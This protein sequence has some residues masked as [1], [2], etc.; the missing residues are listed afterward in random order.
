MAIRVLLNLLGGVALLL[1]G[2]HMVQSG[3][4]RAFGARLKRWLARVLRH[5][6]KA[7]LAGLVVTA[8]LQS[9]TATA[10]MI[11][12]FSAVNLVELTPALAVMLGANVGTTLV[13]Q[14]LSFDTSLLSPVLLFVGLI[15]FR[16]GAQTVTRDLGRV[17]IGLGLMLLA[18]HLM[19]ESLAPVEHAVLVH[20]LLAALGDEPLLM[21]LIGAALTWAAHSSVA[22]VLFAS[23]LA[24]TGALD[25]VPALVLVL[26]ANLGSAINPLLESHGG[27]PAHLRLPFANLLIRFIGCLVFLP[28]LD[29]AAR[30][31][32]GFEAN[33]LRQVADFHTL[34]NLLLAVAFFPALD[35]LA[36]LLERLL[37]DTRG[38]QDP[39]V[40]V[41]LDERALDVPAVALACAARETLRLGEL[42][43]TMLRQGMQAVFANDRKLASEVSRM[44]N[45][46]DR[47]HEAIKL[48]LVRLIRASDDEAVHRR[49]MELM[50]LALNLEHIGDIIDKNLMELATKKIKRHLE[51]SDEGRH[52][53][54][55]FHRLVSDNLQLALS[56]CLTR[57]HELA[58]MLR[59][60][61]SRIRELELAAVRSHLARL[62][63]GRAESIETSSLHLDLLRDL[64][65]IHSHVCAAVYPLLRA[66]GGAERDGDETVPV[67]TIEGE[68]GP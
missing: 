27:N 46:V 7:F 42:V 5:R 55:E 30:L 49:A 15:A 19:L 38:G 45:A 23:S 61:K 10:L 57:D 20:E 53:L 41:H 13:V 40:P 29:P 17:A 68:E 18:L 67:E 6:A 59:E 3:L 25:T 26:G 24:G 51:F 36:R 31:L 21:L 1:W 48:Y 52:E 12:S 4:L 11:S 9:S 56:A 34:F 35:L 14:L 44:D 22:I 62:Q 50:A 37:P 63:E 65:R 66:D 33:P 32:S 8:I 58:R 16:R 43:E 60:E 64:K 39:A 47:L 28:L 54:E 2:L